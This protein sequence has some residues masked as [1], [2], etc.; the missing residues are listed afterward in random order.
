[1]NSSHWLPAVLCALLVV[2]AGCATFT[3]NDETSTPE[4]PT[5]EP[6][7]TAELTAQTATTESTDAGTTST[8]E[9]LAPGLTADGVTDALALANAHRDVITGSAWTQRVSFER[10]N[11]TAST[12]RN[13]TL[14]YANSSHWR[15]H[16]TSA[17][18]ALP[19]S[20]TEGTV[21]LYADGQ[22][23]VRK[24]RTDGNVTHNVVRVSDAADAPPVPPAEVL[25]ESVFGRDA[26]YAL[27]GNA[28]VTV[29]D[30]QGPTYRLT[31]T[32]E[33][34]VV[35]QQPATNVE[36]T[37]NVTAD[38][39]VRTLDVAYEQ[40]DASVERSLTVEPADGDPVERPDWYEMAVNGTNGE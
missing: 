5:A 18:D 1:M 22:R 7:A 29:A 14:S 38:G 3:N 27:F 20:V 34:L 19:A 12:S 33:E 21:D 40:G 39:L 30:A 9:Q 10:T 4:Q 37:A 35:D 2:S 16:I 6:T 17:G 28:D 25:P 36:F 13:T 23:V 26:L 15:W 31:G 32:A 11:D 8:A 24:L